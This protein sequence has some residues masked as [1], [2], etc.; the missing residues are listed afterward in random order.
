MSQ[1]PVHKHLDAPHHTEIQDQIVGKVNVIIWAW[2]VHQEDLF[3]EKSLSAELYSQI[4]RIA[5]GSV[6]K[7]RSRSLVIDQFGREE[8]PYELLEDNTSFCIT[9]PDITLRVV[10]IQRLLDSPLILLTWSKLNE[11]TM[12]RGPFIYPFGNYFP[13]K[14]LFMAWSFFILHCFQSGIR[15]LIGDSNKPEGTRNNIF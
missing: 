15:V 8:M 13:T 9:I 11:I 6:V 2:C 12:K 10:P 4:E 5:R 1:C 3:V 7:G 14:V